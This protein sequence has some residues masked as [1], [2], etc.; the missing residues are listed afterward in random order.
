MKLEK[1]FRWFGPDDNISLKEIRQ[2]GATGIVTALHHIPNGAIWNQSEI[3]TRLDEIQQNG[4]IW[5]V[6]ESLPVH[7]SI[8]AGLDERD[9]LIENYKVSMA[10]LAKHGID[11]I[12]YNFMPVLDWV[13]T[14]LSYQLPDGGITMH[15]D[16]IT[17]AAFDIYIL[18]RPEAIHDYSEEVIHLAEQRFAEMTD[19]EAEEIAHTII[20]ITQGFIDGLV[21]GSQGDYKSIFLNYIKEY[22]HIGITELRENLAYFLDRIIPT[23]EKYGIKMAIHADDP[24]FPVLGLPRIVSTEKDLDWILNRNKSVNNGLTFCT[25]SFS[26]CKKNNIVQMAEKFADRIHFLHLRNT[27]YIS[28]YEFIESG[29]LEG[30]VDMFSVIKT[31]N[32][33]NRII[34]MRPDHGIKILSDLDRNTNPGYP[35]LGRMKGLA[36]LDGLHNQ[37]LLP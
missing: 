16:H 13:R 10:N 4:L 18:K 15:Y 34:P 36:E 27:K 37:K 7:N 26:S 14:N 11:T 5:R 29:H 35:L 31:M 17:F 3:K 25:G 22:E 1:S 19:K 28:K 20:V 2:I 23:A 12:C 9:E 33:Q 21:D 6:V 8:K 24:A 30:D 32:S